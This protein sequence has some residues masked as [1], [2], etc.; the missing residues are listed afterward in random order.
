VINN[1]KPRNTNEVYDCVR[2]RINSVNACIIQFENCYLSSRL[3]ARTLKIRAYKTMIL[4][5]VLYG[6]KLKLFL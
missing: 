6:V 1:T 4:P 3:H 5:V 2:R